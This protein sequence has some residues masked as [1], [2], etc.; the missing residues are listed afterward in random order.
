[1]ED[2]EGAETVTIEDKNNDLRPDESRES[3]EEAPTE[4]DMIG[5]QPVNF[6]KCYDLPCFN[7]Y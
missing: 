5:S 1:M 7:D 2:L 6:I 4:D 3:S